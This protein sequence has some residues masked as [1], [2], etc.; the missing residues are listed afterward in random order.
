MDR[1][2]AMVGYAIYAAGKPFAK[3]ALKSR[4]GR[5]KKKMSRRIPKKAIAAAAVSAVG[6]VAFWRTR[7]RRSDSAADVGGPAQPLEG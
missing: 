4:T 6:A 2:K 1:R 3:R 7:R 5:E